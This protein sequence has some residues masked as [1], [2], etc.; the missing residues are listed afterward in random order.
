MHDTYIFSTPSVKNNIPK[1]KGQT[2][3]R[4]VHLNATY[5]PGIKLIANKLRLTI[6]VIITKYLNKAM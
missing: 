6:I 3:K 2:A 1:L 5:N 4:G